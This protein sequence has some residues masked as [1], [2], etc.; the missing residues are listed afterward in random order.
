MQGNPTAV[1]DPRDN[2]IQVQVFDLV[3]RVLFRGAADE[4]YTPTN[5]AGEARVLPDAAGAPVRVWRSG[6]TSGLVLCQPTATTGAA[7]D[8]LLACDNA[9]NLLCAQSVI[10]NTY[11]GQ[12]NFWT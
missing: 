10:P 12:L 3:G 11:L 5:G 1:V 2:T 9:G 8:I 4:G 7:S 6:D